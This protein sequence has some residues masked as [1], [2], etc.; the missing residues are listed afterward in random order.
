MKCSAYKLYSASTTS[1]GLESFSSTL[2]QKS[3]YRKGKTMTSKK[4]L[5]GYTKAHREAVF[6]YDFSWDC[7]WYWG[8]GYIGNR[9]FHAHFNGAFLDVVDVRGHCLGNF[10]SPWDKRDDGIVVQNGASVW[11][12]IGFFLDEVPVHIAENW[13]RIKDLY[14]QFY[15]LKAAAEV[16]AYGGHLTSSG[17]KPEELVPEMAA[18]I[19]KHIQMVIIP[20]VREIVKFV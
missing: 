15:V 3:L 13:W 12:D 8:G 7:G 5:L 10:K 1:R 17:R 6:L 14:K 18:A 20:A 11:E 16:F 9:N 4:T 2:E 19:N